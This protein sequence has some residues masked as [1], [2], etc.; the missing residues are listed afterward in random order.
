M[1]EGRYTVKDT[2]LKVINAPSDVDIFVKNTGDTAVYLSIYPGNVAASGEIL[3]PTD[4]KVWQAGQELYVATAAGESTIHLSLN[5][6]AIWSPYDIAKQITGGSTLSPLAVAQELNAIGV[7]SVDKPVD[8]YS[9]TVP[10]DGVLYQSFALDVSTFKSVTWKC[11]VS[12]PATVTTPP[13]V[14]FVGFYWYASDATTILDIDYVNLIGD[15]DR[16]SF[17]EFSTGA[18]S[19]KGAYLAVVIQPIIRIGGTVELSVRGTTAEKK[20]KT[21]MMNGYYGTSAGTV[22]SYGLD[23]YVRVYS[24]PA[25]TSG[26]STVEWFPVRSGLATIHCSYNGTVPTAGLDF[27]IQDFN[28]VPIGGVRAAGGGATSFSFSQSLYLPDRPVHIFMR[29]KGPST[30]ATVMSF[31]ITYEPE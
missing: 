31:V 7:P 16:F 22:D 8:I 18:L 28:N 5:A 4:S 21:W 1:Y 10:Q 14:I 26:A 25:L 2:P 19:V 11:R 17:W 30:L 13:G 23:R 29:N 3:N 9:T 6:G 27:L 15:N 12:D 24:A 20:N